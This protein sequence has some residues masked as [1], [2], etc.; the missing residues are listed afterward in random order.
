MPINTQDMLS[1]VIIEITLIV[2]GWWKKVN[3]Y[4]T[5]LFKQSHIVKQLCPMNF[6]NLW[7]SFTFNYNVIL[8]QKI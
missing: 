1:L 7:D 6:N 5:T 2:N 8:A 4:S 3:K